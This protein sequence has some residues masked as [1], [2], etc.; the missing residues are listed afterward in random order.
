MFQ[1]LC[2]VPAGG[3]DSGLPAEA[4]VSA[5]PLDEA[6]QGGPH[7]V[8]GV[9]APSP[10]PLGPALPR[11]WLRQPPVR[12]LTLLFMS[13]LVFFSLETL[14]SG[15]LYTAC[16]SLGKVGLFGLSVGSSLH[17]T[18]VGPAVAAV[19][20]Q[21]LGDADVR[22]SLKPLNDKI[23]GGAQCYRKMSVPV[24]VRFYFTTACGPRCGCCCFTVTERQNR[25]QGV[26]M[27][28]SRLSGI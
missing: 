10:A 16:S 9:P 1:V 27:D 20:L 22:N 8:C 2:G 26:K 23:W 4:A 24:T 17:W 13:D 6:A 25:A 11:R 14:V 3:P 18:R 7:G 28:V 19:L 5:H 15:S 12:V 21:R